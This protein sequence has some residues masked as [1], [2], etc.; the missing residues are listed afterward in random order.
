MHYFT[1][2][3]YPMYVYQLGLTEIEKVLT[4]QSVKYHQPL[5]IK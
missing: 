5:P 2:H 1:T 4:F 3:E